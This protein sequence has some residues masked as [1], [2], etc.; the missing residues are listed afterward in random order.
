MGSRKPGKGFNKKVK[1]RDKNDPVKSTP[2][3]AIKEALSSMEKGF[4]M[5]S[6]SAI[7]FELQELENMFCLLL[8][9][10][11]AGIPCPPSFLSLDLLPHL[12]R[13]LNGH[14]LKK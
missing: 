5:S 11:F 13:E 2:F 9:A 7:Q 14:A 10:S 8:L 3:K 6:V 12:E 1:G 4:R